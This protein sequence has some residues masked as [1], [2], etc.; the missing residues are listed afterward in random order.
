M[1]FLFDKINKLKYN[2]LRF[3]EGAQNMI[4]Y[5]KILKTREST[6]YNQ[7]VKDDI[8]IASLADVHISRLVGKKDIDNISDSLY[9]LNPDYICMLGDLIDSPKYLLDDKKL[10]ELEI[11]L[12]NSA[13]IA[14]TILV[15][16]NHDIA[17]KES[18][19]IVDITEKTDIWN[20]ITRRENIHLLTDEL[21]KDNRIVIGGYKQKLEAYINLYK[22]HIEDPQA[23]YEDFKARESLYKNLPQD[24]P[25]ILITHSPE[26]IIGLDIKDILSGYDLILTGHYHNGCV[27][28]IL[29]DIYPKNAG[30][31]T[32]EKKLFPRNA[33][34]IIKLNNGTIMI[35]NGG[36][37]KIAESAPKILHKTNCMFY[38][39]MDL[40]T[41]T[42]DEDFKE[43]TVKN[44]LLLLKR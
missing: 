7:Y 26:T 28:A 6:I 15:L 21:Y 31:I 5:S 35:Y 39:Q 27:P 16:G 22:K 24:L 19:K 37:T 3:Q 29:D 36:W 14:P 9:E 10:K 34:D 43:T 38:R 40:T 25:K 41:L 32:P 13:S 2:R 30:I 33:R 18:S 11:L 23:F 4:D 17:I 8:R 44:K 12:S 1:V 20:Q 42:S